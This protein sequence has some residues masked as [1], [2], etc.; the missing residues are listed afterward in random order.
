M[1]AAIDI[2]AVTKTYDGRTR[3]VDAVD[4]A[5]REGEFFSL[6]GPS[7]C[8]KTTTLRMIAGFETPTEGTIAVGGADVTHVPAHKRDMGMVFQNYAL[9]PHRSVGENVGFGLRMRGMDRA[10]IARKVTDALAQVE[11]VGYEDRRPGQ[12]SGGQQ[13][14][15]ALARAIVIEPRVLLCDEPLGALDKKLR[16]SMQFELKQLQRK[17]GLTMVF[18]T[19]DQE[20]ALAMSDR[21]AVMNAGKVEQIGTPSEI[22]DR[23]GTRFVADF[24]GDTNLFRGEVIRT[25]GT[26]V[27]RVDSD[28]SIE[29][30]EEPGTTGPLSVALRPEKIVLTAPGAHAGQGLDGI[31]ESA[32]FQGGSV[33]YRIEAAGRRLL[34]QQ[35]NNGS[36]ELFQ[37]GAAVA[38]RWTPSDIVILKD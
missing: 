28:L 5:I 16:Q 15:V 6:L 8:G 3:A 36:H 23:P 9:F 30:A 19:H 7:G 38:L 29:L 13:Q 26:C 22:Y 33:L 1:S 35:P 27:L 18:V 4:M 20:E 32:N 12:L 37:A 14:R 21:I 11:L 31:V 24:I 25:G 10:M 34:A 17:L 2:V